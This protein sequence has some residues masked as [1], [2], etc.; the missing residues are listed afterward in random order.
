MVSSEYSR[1]AALELNDYDSIR[2]TGVS[3]S[4]TKS[5]NWEEGWAWNPTPSSGTL[6]IA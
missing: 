1:E 4:Q 2:K 6:T 3:Q 5:Q